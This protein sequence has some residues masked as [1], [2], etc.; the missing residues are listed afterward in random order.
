MF[1]FRYRNY[2]KQGYP[3]TNTLHSKSGRIYAVIKRSS[4]YVVCAGYSIADGTWGQ[5]YYGFA[6]RAKAVNFA[7]RLAYGRR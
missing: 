1:L 5:G 4:D 3:V 6:T 2:T 7:K